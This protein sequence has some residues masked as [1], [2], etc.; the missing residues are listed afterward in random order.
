MKNY[1]MMA[2]A[3]F[4]LSACASMAPTPNTAMPYAAAAASSDQFEIQSSQTAL[5]KSQNAEVRRYA[6]MLI[7]HHTQTSATLAR[8]AQEAGMAP[9]PPV[10]MPRHAAMLRTIQAAPADR[11]DRVYLTAQVPAH[12]EALA[13][14][15]NY[16]ANGDTPSL[17]TAAGAA[18][19]FVQQHL[20]EAQSMVATMAAR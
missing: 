2:G 6:Q 1:L 5:T 3:A 14:H 11:F 17:R 13:L 18:V 4:A 9:P 19:P 12:Q 16:A 7:E 8:A 15:Q 10:L 20:T